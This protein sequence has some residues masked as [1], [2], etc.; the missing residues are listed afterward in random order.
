MYLSW[1]SGG[2]NWFLSLAVSLPVRLVIDTTHTSLGWLV[3]HVEESL[4]FTCDLL[5]FE[6]CLVCTRVQRS[7]IFPLSWSSSL[8]VM[9]TK[10]D[11]KVNST[12]ST[13]HV[14]LQSKRQRS[15]ERD[16]PLLRRLLHLSLPATSVESLIVCRFFSLSLPSW[17]S[18]SNDTLEYSPLSLCVMTDRPSACDWAEEQGKYSFSLRLSL[19]LSLCRSLVL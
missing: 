15:G 7:L 1:T 11:D 4:F 19:S 9:K 6:T 10:S 3:N 13:T 18:L 2:E 5:L 14:P 8:F 12:F 16:F 17:S